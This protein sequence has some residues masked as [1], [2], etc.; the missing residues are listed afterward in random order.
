MLATAQVITGP[1]IMVSMDQFL[2][3]LSPEVWRWVS[4]ADPKSTDQLVE[5]LDYY[6][7]TGDLLAESTIEISSNQQSISLRNHFKIS[8]P[9]GKAAGG[10][11]KEDSKCGW[12]AASC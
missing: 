10:K 5:L 2:R 6:S 8:I 3:D 11:V 4:Q 7:A 9:A 12:R 1:K